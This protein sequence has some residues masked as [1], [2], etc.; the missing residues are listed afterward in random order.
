MAGVQAL[1]GKA[2]EMVEVLGCYFPVVYAPP[3]AVP[4]GEVVPRA[5]LASAVEHALAAAPALAPHAVPLLLE[6]L[7]SSLRW[8]PQ[9][10]LV[11]TRMP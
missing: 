9:H 6:K 10:C 1:R 8:G 5:A 7:A 11:Q 2:E 3:P 4:V